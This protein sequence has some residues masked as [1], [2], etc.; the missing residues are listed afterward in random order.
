M[1]DFLKG[2]LNTFA[3]GPYHRKG[4]CN[5]FKIIEGYSTNFG[6]RFRIQIQHRKGLLNTF[7]IGPYHRKG[8]E[9]RFKIL[10]EWSRGFLNRI[11]VRDNF[12][13]SLLSRP[14]SPFIPIPP[15]IIPFGV[16]LYYNGVH[17]PL[18]DYSYERTI[19]QGI[20]WHIK[21]KKP[22]GT[23]I[24]EE[25]PLHLCF[26]Y[27][28]GPLDYMVSPRLSASIED[29]EEGLGIGWSCSIHG[30]DYTS[31]YMSEEGI[32]YPTFEHTDIITLLR[33]LAG[34]CTV[35]F[36][37]NFNNYTIMEYDVHGGKR[38]EYF[39]RL[40]HDIGHD[41]F[42]GDNGAFVLIPMLEAYDTGLG[43]QFIKTI[44]RSRNAKNKYTKAKI[45]KTSKIQT[46]YEF[47][48]TDPGHKSFTFN[49][50]LKPESIRIWDDSVVGYVD[51]IGLFDDTSIN[52][53]DLV[54]TYILFSQ[55]SNTTMPKPTSSR[56]VMA[57]T[58]V[59]FPPST[60]LPG[61]QI[62][63]RLIIEGIP[64]NALYDGYDLTFEVI[65]DTGELPARE[66]PDYIEGIIIPTKEIANNI[67]KGLLYNRIKNYIIYD[68]SSDYKLPFICPGTLFSYPDKE[69]MRI[70]KITVNPGGTN[71]GC[72]RMPWW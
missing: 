21:L 42:I 2:F 9:N 25:S 49:T 61:T 7:A 10:R 37:P 34:N 69:N 50:P 29:E 68:I 71:L 53:A 57:G 26:K 28:P 11:N 41:W 8:F 39:N 22:I 46:V 31:Y 35:E 1:S 15:T 55:N 38:I 19:N 23:T 5:R 13:G 18:D 52:T 66:L 64:A 43:Y 48:F 44:K 56:P 63:A 47:V 40:V 45:I 72:V 65:E 58:C 4:F 62:H 20:L 60:P 51:L 24:T 3:I 30:S 17:Y 12:F 36:P 70:E 33:T 32:D 59:V 67:K 6:N 27:G 16:S 14:N 54:G